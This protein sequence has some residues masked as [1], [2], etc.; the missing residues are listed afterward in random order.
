M[1]HD[2]RPL[3]SVQCEGLHNPTLIKH[4]PGHY[5]HAPGSGSGWERATV[6]ESG[7]EEKQK[8]ENRSEEVREAEREE[9]PS[10]AFAPDVHMCCS[11]RRD[12]GWGSECPVSTWLGQDN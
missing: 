12:G 6:S 9:R 1:A 4:P 7:W 3:C 5:T 10:A 11:L 8:Q 2:H